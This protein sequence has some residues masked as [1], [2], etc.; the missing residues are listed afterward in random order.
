MFKMLTPVLCRAALEAGQAIM[1]VYATDFAVDYKPDDSPLTLADREA[2]A[3]ITGI[4]RSEF[5]EVPVLSEESPE[6]PERERLS[7]VRFFLVDPLDG[8]KEFVKRNG[9]FTVNIAMV[10]KNFPAFGVVYAPLTDEL[11]YGGKDFG[12]FL[13]IGDE[14]PLALSTVKPAAGA[15]HRVVVSRSHA[16]PEIETYLSTIDVAERIN[17]GSALK[18]TMLAKGAA[19]LYPRFSPTHEWDTAAGQ[20]VLEGAGG[21]MTNWDDSPFVY[22]KATLLNPGFIARA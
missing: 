14:R 2:H 1:K 13:K 10:A 4:L 12:S 19:D 5:P 3:I 8:T 11:Y 15:G 7:W 16:A 22:N 20:A 6:V 9:E 21:T 17:V 18:F